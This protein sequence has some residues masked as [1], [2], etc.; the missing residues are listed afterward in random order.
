M[1]LTTT[2][3]QASIRGNKDEEIPNQDFI[4]LM[5]NDDILIATYQMG[6]A[7]PSIL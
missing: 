6:W 4:Q 5:E 1:K 7:L 2:V 3:I